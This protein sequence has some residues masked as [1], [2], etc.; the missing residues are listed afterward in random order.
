VKITL[1]RKILGL[2][3]A[4]AALPVL[5]I[6]GLMIEFKRSVA[7]KAGSEL[8]A[9]GRANITQIAR[10]VYNLCSTA[11]ELAQEKVDRSLD[12]ARDLLARRGG[13]HTGSEMVAWTAFDQVTGQ[14]QAVELPRLLVGG[15]WLGDNRSFSVTTPFVDDVK[16]L[17]G[18]TATVFQRMNER[19]DMLRVATNIANADG[20]RAVGTYIAA[21]EPDGTPNPVVASVLGGQVYRGLAHILGRPY[22]TAYEPL[23]TG[24]G[25]VI[26]ML[27][28]G[29]EISALNSLRR[30]IMSTKVGGT[31]YVAVIGCRGQNRGRYVISKDGK[32]DGDDIWNAR[33][34]AGDL[35]IQRMVQRGLAAPRGEVFYEEYGWKNTDEE[36]PRRKISALVY[37]EPWDWLINAGTYEDDYFSAVKT[38]DSAIGGLTG[39]VVGAGIAALAL[40]LIFAV[41]L[42]G[43]LARPLG[44]TAGVAKRIAGGD[45]LEARRELSVLGNGDAQP[46]RPA[47]WIEDVDEAAELVESFRA[48]TGRLDSLIGQVQRSGIQVN[49]SALQIAASARQLEATVAEQAASTREVTAT[50]K[51]IS[52]T[53]TDLLRTMGGVSESVAQAGGKAESGQADLE[54]MRA[55]MQQLAQATNSIS[56]KLGVISERANKISS[57]VATI[58]KISDQ[59][60]L[61][62][63]NA[64]I[65]AEKAG[66]HG[67]GFSVVAREISRLADQTA[68]STHDI[69]SVVREMQSSVSSGVMEMDRFSEE[70]RRRAEEVGT[71][72]QQL[73]QIIEQVQT[74]GPQFEAV[75]EG[76]NVQ[77]QGA[78]QISEAMIQ[79]SQAAEQTRESL[80][81]FKQAT[82]QLNGAVQGLQS[83]VAKFHISA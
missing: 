46:H 60:G 37:F 22:V 65:E 23:R 72:G 39:K 15:T 6:L 54:R 9:M 25:R 8:K 7:E 64:A 5:V 77:T 16:R 67:R 20:S 10:D 3:V 59:T 47:R 69:E 41:F 83:E 31:G 61:L 13:A 74:L 50:S 34:A 33:D 44:V 27:Y 53:S 49:A 81:E 80:Q 78:Q 48:M 51:E 63:L 43:K 26:G 52:A 56:A 29:E 79:L 32:R 36:R 24:G 73:A 2:A 76:M 70:V 1:K 19:G 62:A 66:E 35:L 21:I 14:R 17:T 40:A 4:A 30:A 82:E 57:V 75:Q 42:S 12:A 68:V 58:N 18:G 38:V 55:A 28:A 71:V 11:N 45:L